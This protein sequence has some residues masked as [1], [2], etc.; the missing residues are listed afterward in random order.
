MSHSNLY[1]CPLSKDL[2]S[3]NSFVNDYDDFK[4]GNSKY[5]FEMLRDVSLY[6]EDDKL[7]NKMESIIPVG[8]KIYIVTDEADLKSNTKESR[9]RLDL[10][11]SKYDVVTQVSMS[12]TNIG[13]ASKIF[14]NVPDSEIFY[15][16]LTYNDLLYVRLRYN[17]LV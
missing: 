3:N 12:G 15:K 4:Y 5:K 1:L 17:I 2:S 13:R 8:S 16:K 14:I 6:L 11:K 10:I 7:V 9:K